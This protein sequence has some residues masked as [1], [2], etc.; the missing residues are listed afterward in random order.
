[1]RQNDIEGHRILK[2]D[3]YSIA[4]ET[5]IEQGDILLSINDKTIYDI[6]DYLE[7]IADEELVLLIKKQS[8]EEWEIEIEKEAGEDLGISFEQDLLDEQRSCTNKCIFCFI[9]QMPENMRKS[10]YY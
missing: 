7:Y 9:D 8:G 6:L 3:T 2:V 4:Q 5:G 10:L 1:M